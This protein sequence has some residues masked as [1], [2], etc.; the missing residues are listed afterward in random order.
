MGHARVPLRVNYGNSQ[1]KGRLTGAK[2]ADTAEVNGDG[3]VLFYENSGES[4]FVPVE[5][6]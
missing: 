4:S 3:R 5:I 2:T 6:S 1:F